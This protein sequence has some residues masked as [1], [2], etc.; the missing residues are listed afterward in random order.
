MYLFYGLHSVNIDV[1]WKRYVTVL[2]IAQFVA[3]VIVCTLTYVINFI[4]CPLNIID[5]YIQLCHCHGN[6]ASATFGLAILWSY[7]LL[8]IRLY[9]QI[10]TN[11]T[12]HQ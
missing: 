4:L 1:W 3:V 12:R 6:F 11:K 7:L 9:G 2:Q 5:R 8:F 10:Y